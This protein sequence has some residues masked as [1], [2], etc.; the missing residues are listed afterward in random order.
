MSLALLKRDDNNNNNKKWFSAS[1]AV[2]GSI[3]FFLFLF[4]KKWLFFSKFYWTD[5]V[6]LKRICSSQIWVSLPWYVPNAQQD[7]TPMQTSQTKIVGEE[8]RGEISPS[9]FL[10]FFWLFFIFGWFF[11]IFF[12]F[13]FCFNFFFCFFCCFFFIF[14][15]FIIHPV[16]FLLKK[17]FWIILLL[18][19]LCHWWRSDDMAKCHLLHTQTTQEIFSFHHIWFSLTLFFF[20]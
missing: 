15:F 17:L 8:F 2:N 1:V 14:F 20:K 5:L 3:S 12:V 7:V 11:K 9:V 16:L 18:I 13:L 6:C 19:I 4:F 10:H